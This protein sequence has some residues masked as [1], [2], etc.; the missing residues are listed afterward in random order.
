MLKRTLYFANPYYLSTRNEQLVIVS[1]DDVNAEERTTPIEDLGFLLLEHPQITISHIAIQ[2]LTANNVAVVWC[3]DK[4]LPAS[5]LL[6][7]E[8]HHVQS[9]RFRHQ[10]E[11]TEPLKKQLW[12]QTIKAKLENQALVLDLA[13]RQNAPL[14]R[15][16]RE[17]MSGDTSNKEAQASR[18]FWQQVFEPY[19]PEFHRDRFGDPPNHLLNYGYAIIR[20]ATAR[21]LVGAGLLPTL[22][23]HHHNRYNA[24][25][26]ADDIME[27]YRPW[28]DAVVL[29][30]VQRDEVVFGE[31]TK[32]QKTALLGL[33]AADTY[34]GKE[35]SPL[36][37]ALTRTSNSLAQCFGGN[38]RQLAYPTLPLQ[39]G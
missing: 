32:A 19:V 1:K 23:I 3:D 14:N 15:W 17:V 21:A 4:H 20:A 30:M 13:E 24:Y 2:R 27:P 7:L 38:K 35:R 31:V 16:R 39:K 25:C 29:G 26:L 6:P 36:M 11:A 8:G 34:F 33:L 5:L 18:Y 10:I 37:V 28:V 22:G 9:E 12:Q